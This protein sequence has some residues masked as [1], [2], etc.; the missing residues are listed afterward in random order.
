MAN[1]D[2]LTAANIHNGY[3]YSNREIVVGKWRIK[4]ENFFGPFSAI[5]LPGLLFSTW[6]PFFYLAAYF[7]LV[8]IA[9]HCL[10]RVPWRIKREK[11][12]GPFSAI[13]F[14]ASF[15]YLASFFSTWSPQR[16]WR[17]K[18]ENF[19]GPFSA[20]FIPGLLFFN[21]ASFFLPGLLFLPGHLEY[22]GA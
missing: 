13:F 19:F 18:R 1:I 22:H 17:I 8:T 11:F 3:K 10:P 12:I 5:F 9:A 4:R 2:G 15:F 21:L 16:P 6:P 7:Y 20:I 14:L